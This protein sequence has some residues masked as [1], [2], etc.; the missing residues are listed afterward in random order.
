MNYID[1]GLGDAMLVEA[2]GGLRLLI[3][4]GGFYGSDFDMGKTVIAPILLSK[5]IRTLDWVV[6][7]HPHEDHLGG[8]QHI[9]RHFRVNGFAAANTA[10]PH[11]GRLEDIVE[12]RNIPSTRLAAGDV[13]PLRSGFGIEVLH[14]PARLD[15]DDLNDTSLVLKMTLGSKSFLFT[16]D[17]GENVE[18][19]LILS[20]ARLNSSVL[21]VPHHGSRHSSTTHFIGAVKPQIAVMSVG[22]GIRGIPSDEAIA[23]YMALAIPLYRTDRDGC[24]RVCTNGKQLTV[25]KYNDQ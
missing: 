6:N 8:L 18:R 9:L 17:I 1:V 21:K 12:E 2:P 25:E 13:L 14:P 15:T 24:V 3:D 4:G 7:T 11:A 16:G 19:T 5:K 22:P 10:G 20:E 23:R